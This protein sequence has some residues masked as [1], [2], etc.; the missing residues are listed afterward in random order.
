MALVLQGSL[1]LSHQN[2][3]SMI[4]RLP[5]GEW[6][7]VHRELMEREANFAAIALKAA[8]GEISV[9]ELDEARKELLA[10]REHCNA[11]YARA[12]PKV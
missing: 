2:R 5:I 3:L 8:A 7:K 6:L 1:L 4:D 11:I 10:M 9:A 12:F